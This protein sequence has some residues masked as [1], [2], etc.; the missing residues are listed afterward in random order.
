MQQPSLAPQP[1]AV[2]TQLPAFVHDSMTRNDN[3]NPIEAVGAA[4]GSDRFGAAH[5][6]RNVF[7]RSRL[8]VRDVEQRLPD[9]FF[10]WAAGR[11]DG[12]VEMGPATGEILTQFIL[13]LRQEAMGAGRQ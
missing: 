9:A 7:V 4:D 8:T 1:A 10:K 13:E 5:R 3:R 12:H 6:L 2:A 11:V